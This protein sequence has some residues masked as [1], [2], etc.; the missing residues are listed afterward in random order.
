MMTCSMPLDQPLNTSFLLYDDIMT[1]T[2]KYFRS[3]GHHNRKG[4]SDT[5]SED[6][7][8]SYLIRQNFDPTL[9]LADRAIRA[10]RRQSA[11]QYEAFLDRVDDYEEELEK[12]PLRCS[13]N[14]LIEATIKTRPR[15]RELSRYTSRVSYY[16]SLEF[17][18]RSCRRIYQ[19]VSLKELRNLLSGIGLQQ[20]QQHKS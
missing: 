15:E 5:S 12:K 14:G 6:E 1:M 8:Q 17:V 20:Q 11:K 19:D 2:T 13:C 16:D 4:K 9:I 10:K 7:L 3:Q 18:C